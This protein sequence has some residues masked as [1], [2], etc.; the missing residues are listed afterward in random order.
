MSLTTRPRSHA[1][2]DAIIAAITGYLARTDADATLIAAEAA[3]FAD[4]R[5]QYQNARAAYQAAAGDAEDASERADAAD[6]DFDRAFR[7][8]VASVRDEEGRPAPRQIANMMGG[9]LP[10]DLTRKPYR[11]EVQR[12]RDLLSRLSA[13]DGLDIDEDRIAALA[14]SVDLLEATTE[15]S[16]VATRAA[17]SAGATLADAVT[18]FDQRY[19]KLVRRWDALSD[20]GAVA[21]LLPRFVRASSRASADD[22]AA[23]S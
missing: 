21:A 12:A 14:A 16:E 23:P 4:A 22:E 11:E 15:A 3:V 13:R 6:A 18:D 20:D 2:R 17:R 7:L 5:V 10:G 1:E 9:L 19:G 8:L